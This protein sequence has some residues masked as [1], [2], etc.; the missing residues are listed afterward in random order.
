[1]AILVAYASGGQSSLRS[2]N[3]TDI[4]CNAPKIYEALKRA[5]VRWL[6]NKRWGGEKNAK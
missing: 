4:G 1:L 3:R 6:K 5:K 2:E